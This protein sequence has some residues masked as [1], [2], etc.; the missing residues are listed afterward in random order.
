MHKMCSTEEREKTTR[1]KSNQIERKM[2]NKNKP[3]GTSLTNIGS[4]LISK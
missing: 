3:K 1:Q 4:V 2:W